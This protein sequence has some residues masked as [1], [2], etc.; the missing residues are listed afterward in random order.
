MFSGQA[1]LS[2][3][4]RSGGLNV[5]SYDCNLGGNEFHIMSTP[6]FLKAAGFVLRLE[7]GRLFAAYRA[8]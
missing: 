3:Q 4:L 8:H 6:G 1:E 7:P 2:N 5:R